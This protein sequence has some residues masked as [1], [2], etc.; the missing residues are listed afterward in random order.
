LASAAICQKWG[1]YSTC[2]MLHGILRFEGFPATMVGHLQKKGGI[3]SHNKYLWYA[4]SSLV[5]DLLKYSTPNSSTTSSSSSISSSLKSPI[6]FSMNN[7][8]NPTSPFKKDGSLSRGEAIKFK[9][10]RS[11]LISQII[12][13]LI[14]LDDLG[15]DDGFAFSIVKN[16]I[17]K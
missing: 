14:E 10:L 6:S 13:F 4:N 15:G 11:V 12:I 9:D 8:I 3:G 17:V 5:G 7:S 16:G 1:C 2:P